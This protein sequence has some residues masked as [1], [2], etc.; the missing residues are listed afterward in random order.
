MFNEIV[1]LV[2]HLTGEELESRNEKASNFLLSLDPDITKRG[3]V[4]VVVVCV[5]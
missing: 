2:C 1:L 5:L 3:K 4:S